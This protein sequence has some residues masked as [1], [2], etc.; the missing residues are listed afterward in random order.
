[1]S[2]EIKYDELIK[3]PSS[4]YVDVQISNTKH[5]M[6]ISK[7]G[8]IDTGAYITVIPECMVQQLN[9]KSSGI[10]MAGGFDSNIWEYDTYF[11]NVKIYDL[12][13]RYVKVIAQSDKKRQ[14][15]LVGRNLLNLWHM[16]LNGE[17][18]KGEFTSFSHAP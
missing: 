4:P 17:T 8:M 6:Y 10:E 12:V 2:Y 15:I 9:L 18:H 5:E 1:M 13:Y 16:K 14:N 3:Y 7:N 11:I